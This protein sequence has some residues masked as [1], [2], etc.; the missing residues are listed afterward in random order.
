MQDKNEEQG[1]SDH[2]GTINA[3]ANTT[4]KND[5][6]KEEDRRTN[7]VKMYVETDT[8]HTRMMAR[9]RSKEVSNKKKGRWGFHKRYLND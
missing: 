7:G 6:R 3:K 9:R 2:S 5:V 8:Q 1:I 4:N